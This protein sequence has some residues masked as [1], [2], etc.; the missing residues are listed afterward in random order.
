MPNWCSNI[1]VVGHGDQKLLRRFLRGYRKGKLAQEF[2]PMPPEYKKDSRWHDW[3]V[4]NWGVKWD[5][6][7]GENGA[8]PVQRDGEVE[9]RFSTDW[10]PPIE[11][12]LEMRLLGF[13]INAAFYEPG[14]GFCGRVRNDEFEDFGIRCWKPDC[15]RRF[16][17]SDL[18]ELF[19]I[20]DDST[21]DPGDEGVCDHGNEPWR[22][23]GTLQMTV[24]SNRQQ[25]I[26]RRA[27]LLAVQEALA[28]DRDTA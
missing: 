21:Q 8:P 5:F 12:Y 7:Q 26:E 16:I 10:T 13:D 1:L 24:E 25:F 22:D 27:L 11:F 18:V 17:A 14:V 6:G 23:A 20:H 2:L 3:R 15:V 19:G 9:V 4:L 28:A